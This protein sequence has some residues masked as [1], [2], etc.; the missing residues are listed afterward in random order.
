MGHYPLDEN[1]FLDGEQPMEKKFFRRQTPDPAVA[2]LADLESWR[3]S[4]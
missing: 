2:G 1:Q 3:L 4:G